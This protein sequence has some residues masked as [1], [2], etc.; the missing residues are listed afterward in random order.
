MLQNKSTMWVVLYFIFFSGGAFLA[1]L[2]YQQYQKTE[3]LLDKGIRTKATVTQLVPY[4]SDDGTTYAP[5]FEFKDTQQRVHSFESSI[6]SS[7][8][9]YKVGEKVKVVYDNKDK[10]NVKTISFWGLYRWSVILS[11][12]AAP[13]IVLGGSYLWYIYF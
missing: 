7:P 6:K 2:A 4:R 10:T 5:V 1:Y 8:A 9:P 3:L 13:L 11:M 12:I